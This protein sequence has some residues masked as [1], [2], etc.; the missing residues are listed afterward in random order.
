MLLHCV[1]EQARSACCGGDALC[2]VQ[3]A[4]VS[5]RRTPKARSKN[6]NG[7]HCGGNHSIR[8]RSP[9]IG[10]CGF[11]SR[12]IGFGSDTCC[13]YRDTVAQGSSAG[14][15]LLA[16]YTLS[17]ASLSTAALPDWRARVRIWRIHACACTCKYVRAAYC[18]TAAAEHRHGHFE[19]WYSRD[20]LRECAIRVRQYDGRFYVFYRE[21]PQLVLLV[22]LACGRHAP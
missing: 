20:C 19:H 12:C 14:M 1:D 11:C 18:V 5:C 3:W 22:A 4:D 9:P 21:T 16:R 10:S 8:C 7:H 15:L 2:F 6:C 17:P 13:P